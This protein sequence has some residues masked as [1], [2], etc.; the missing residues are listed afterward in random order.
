LIQ[1]LLAEVVLVQG[2]KLFWSSTFH[3][4]VWHF[5]GN[6]EFFA[7][8]VILIKNILIACIV[9]MC[10]FIAL[11]ASMLSVVAIHVFMGDDHI[12]SPPS[13]AATTE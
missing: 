4:K 2:R 3:R 6:W 1:P 8:F 12:C 11:E 7:H 9:L 5:E 13:H 10:Y